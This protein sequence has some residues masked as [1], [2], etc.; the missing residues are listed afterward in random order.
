MSNERQ[1][2][3]RLT[4]EWSKRGWSGAGVAA[5]TAVRSLAQGLT[6]ADAARKLPKTFYVTNKVTQ[7]RITEIIKEVCSEGHKAI[8]TEVSMNILFVSAGPTNETRL[9]LDAELRDIISK[10]R[11]TKLRD[12]MH[13]E[14]AVAARQGDVLNAFN[15]HKPVIVHISGHAN[16]QG[17]ALEDDRGDTDFVLIDRVGKLVSLAGSQLKVV[18]LNAC[19]SADQA[20]ML[21]KYVDV[22]VGMNDSITDDAARSFAVQFYSSLGEDMTVKQAFEQAKFAVGIDN[23][24]EEDIPVAYFRNGINPESYRLT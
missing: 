10:I 14:L 21:T 20:K 3:Q 23:I 17:L 22:A 19:E 5:L 9:R 8:D 11:S 24:A 15:I 7:K 1:L 4:D 12:N 18:L 2:V 6:P 13:L 16:S